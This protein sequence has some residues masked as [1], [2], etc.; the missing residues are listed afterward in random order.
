MGGN[1]PKDCRKKPAAS[2]TE[3]K[4]STVE[5]K[6]SIHCYGPG[7]IRREC[8]DCNK[9]EKSSEVN[10]C[11]IVAI[12]KPGRRPMVLI[13]ILGETGTAVVDTG[14]RSSIGS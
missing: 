1:D 4:G 3:D 14:A 10:F 11:A 2:S 13:E 12:V 8:P 5:K 6:Q 7:F 9:L